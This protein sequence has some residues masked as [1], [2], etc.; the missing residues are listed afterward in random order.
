MRAAFTIV[1]LLVTLAILGVLARQQL[2]GL[3]PALPVAHAAAQG[4]S[5]P[6]P[7]GSAMP[8]NAQQMKDFQQQLER[9]M[10][11][12]AADRGKAADALR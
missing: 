6:A 1:S 12:A 2:Q 5:A 8:T 7:L 10:A 9:E 3:R 4:A 11:Q